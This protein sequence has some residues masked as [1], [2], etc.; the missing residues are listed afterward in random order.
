V[1]AERNDPYLSF[2]FQVEIEGV[3]VGGFSDVSGLGVEIETEELR[4]GGENTFPHRLPRGARYQNLVLTRGITDSDLLWA[5]CDE[6]VQGRISRKRASILLLDSEGEEKWRWN[7]RNALP[8]K[9]S[10]P[11]LH[12]AG[13]GVAIE[14]LELSHEGLQK[15]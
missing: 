5:W 12:A 13:R 7:V 15:G 4:E 1:T 10:G 3:I 14:S 2:R 6:T 9:W 8:V 11:G